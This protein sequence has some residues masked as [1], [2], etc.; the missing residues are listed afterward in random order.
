MLIICI[1]KYKN[2]INIQSFWNKIKTQPDIWFFY[3][4]LFTFVF[5]I[6]KVIDSFPIR[7]TKERTFNEYTGIY[8]YISDIF[9]FFTILSWI[10]FILSNNNKIL[11]RL[12]LWI[13]SVIHKLYCKIRLELK[14]LFYNNSKDKLKLISD[15]VSH[16]S[17]NP[18]LFHVKQ[19]F[20]NKLFILLPFVFLIWS[21]SSIIWSQNQIVALFRC[22][23]LF[24]YYLLY[25][26]IALRIVPLIGKKKLVWNIAGIIIFFGLFEA[27]IGIFQFIFQYSV[28]IFWLKESLVSPNID[29]VAKVV[30][31]GHKY[32][33]AYGLFPH[34]NILGG[35]LLL[36][37][38]ITLL[39]KQ[40]FYMEQCIA[41]PFRRE[42]LLEMRLL[43][44]GARRADENRNVSCGTYLNILVAIQSL[45]LLLTFSKS[46]MIALTISIAYIYFPR[47]S[48]EHLMF[49]VKQYTSSSFQEEGA[50]R[51]DKGWNVPCR[52]SIITL[53][54]NANF[55]VIV[56]I[57]LIFLFSAYLSWH[58]ISPIVYKSLYQR[59]LYLNVSCGTILSN[60]IM[61]VGMGQ[62]VLNMSNFVNNLEIWQFQ[63]VHNVFLL[64]WSELG[65]V[66]LGLSMYWLYRMFRACSVYSDCSMWNNQS[67]YEVKQSKMQKNKTPNGDLPSDTESILQNKYYFMSNIIIFL[68]FKAILLGFIFIMLFDHYFWDIQQGSFLFWMTA[69]FIAGMIN[70]GNDKK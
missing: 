5:S 12:K 25:I 70:L 43:Q 39:I 51:V 14:F 44:A 13:T 11:S 17:H 61:G 42:R 58:N 45:A 20:R 56:L 30:I 35:F 37:I 50:R 18:K 1:D 23:K 59:M 38:T 33:R 48:S 36:S 68:Y 26:Y 46:A 34:P 15:D 4:F 41:S 66:G 55:R 31:N 40:L 32:I 6:R 62:F 52:T 60:S 65:I 8:V 63:P 21:F 54:S 16:L 7:G 19:F 49:H 2:M 22:I 10:I 53:R 69:G 9:L 67:I 29:G 3:V 27:I 24:E 28:G 57:V 64:I 47:R